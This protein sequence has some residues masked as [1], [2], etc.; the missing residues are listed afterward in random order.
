MSIV[1]TGAT[2]QIG[3]HLVRILRDAH[4]D[5]TVI[6]LGR[7][8][9]EWDKPETYET[10]FPASAPP[11]SAVFLVLSFDRALTGQAVLISFIDLAISKGVKRFVYISGIVAQPGAFG[12]TKV[13]EYLESDEL[14]A[15]GVQGVTLRPTHFMENFQSGSDLATIKSQNT[16]LSVKG[17]LGVGFIAAQ[18]IAEA[19][20]YFLTCASSDIK[21]SDVPVVGP[22]LLTMD[23]AASVFSSVLGRT[24]THSPR[25]VE[26]RIKEFVGYGLEEGIATAIVKSGA[27]GLDE[28]VFEQENTYKGKKTLKEFVTE[29]QNTWA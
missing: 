26:E 9:F 18:D 11:P 1:V 27:L 8:N 19:A 28:A 15:K 23:Q 29:H 2:G 6:P 5:K 4:P 24:I 25:L 10:A 13:Q 14:K 16:I 17:N 21:Y 20:A 7:P 3:S 12:T 22:E